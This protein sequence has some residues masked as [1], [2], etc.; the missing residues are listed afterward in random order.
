MSARV[1]V[2]TG[3]ARGIGRATAELFERSGWQVV[4]IDREQGDI[5]DE[6]DSRRLFAGVGDRFGRLDALV[7]NAAV[8]LA[9]PLVETSPAEW[10]EVLAVNLRA[11]YLAVRHAHP[12]LCAAGRAAI[13]NVASV[14]ALA[15]S[16]GLAAYAASKGGCVALTRALALELAPDG[17]RVNAV[18]PGAVD[19]GML[20]AGLARFGA[21][22]AESKRRLGALTPLGR[23]GRPEEV[24]EA[25]LFLADAERSS[26]V[27][28]A[29][30]VVDGG[31][32]ATLGTE[33]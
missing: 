9:K 11:H 20:D 17:I 29:S 1:A 6:A 3:A 2:V 15:T 21:D 23:V 27:T 25:I 32:G 5:A 7:N 26:F 18:L 10:D 19:T 24:A 13:V 12:L 33:A 31:A 4:A 8:Q 14:H 28:G 22:V 16:R 30:L